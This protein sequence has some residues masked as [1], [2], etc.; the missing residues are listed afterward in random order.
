MLPYVVYAN[1]AEPPAIIIITKN[2]PAD[3]SISVNNNSM[4]GGSKRQTA[5]ETYFAFYYRDLRSDENINLHVSGRGTSYELTI[6]KSFFKSYSNIVT[7][8]FQNKTI[9]EGKLLSRSIFLISLRVSLT[10]LIEG[11]IFF[12]FGFR[13]KKSWIYFLIINLLTQGALNITLNGSS[14]FGSYV[15]I[16]LFLMEI[17]IWIVETIAFLAFVKEHKKSRR[18]IYVFIANLASLILGGYLIT[19]LP[20]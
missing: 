9:I 8:D 3:I 13:S 2:A 11:L 15:I 1:S 16:G 18:A 10:L 19:I 20:I 6:G 7:L 17:L 4:I 12:L 5:W 14:P